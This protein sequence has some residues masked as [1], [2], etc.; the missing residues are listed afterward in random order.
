MGEEVQLTPEARKRE[1]DWKATHGH[2]CPCWKCLHVKKW[3]AEALDKQQ[4]K[5]EQLT[6]ELAEIRREAGKIV[7]AELMAACEKHKQTYTERDHLRSEN[8]RLRK[9]LEPLRQLADLMDLYEGPPCHNSR[10]DDSYGLLL[11][12]HGDVVV[13]LTVGD[14]RIARKALATGEGG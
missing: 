9:A 7:D 13:E 5:S 1:E 3:W 12:Q 4:Q 11:K 10:A 2:D 14:C 8:A 6:Y